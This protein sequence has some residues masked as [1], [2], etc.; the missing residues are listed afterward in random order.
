[1]MI[2]RIN[3]F[4]CSCSQPSSPILR[5][6]Y[7]ESCFRIFSSLLLLGVAVGFVLYNVEFRNTETPANPPKFSVQLDGSSD[8]SISG[9][10]PSLTNHEELGESHHH[11]HHDSQTSDQEEDEGE[12]H[13]NSSSGHHHSGDTFHQI[14]AITDS[15]EEYNLVIIE[16][17]D[18][19]GVF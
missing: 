3:H 12:E 19:L 6:R 10:P 7:R 1:M 9:G 16:P 15:G 13:G 2:Y 11:H 17:Y 4:H 14:A 5:E 8:S 18:L